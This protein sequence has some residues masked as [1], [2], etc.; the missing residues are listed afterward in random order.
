MQMSSDTSWAGSLRS[1]AVP[2]RESTRDLL[3]S[4]RRPTTIHRQFILLPVAPTLNT[5]W[6]LCPP[7]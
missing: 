7:N 6:G 3:I 1:P 2:G 4:N 5:T